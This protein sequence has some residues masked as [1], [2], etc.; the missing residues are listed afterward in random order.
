MIRRTICLILIRP[1]FV[2]ILPTI[3]FFDYIIYND[4]FYLL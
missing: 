1:F 2:K 3:V 4:F